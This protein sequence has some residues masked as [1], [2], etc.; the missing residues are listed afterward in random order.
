MLVFPGVSAFSRILGAHLAGFFGVMAIPT[1]SI[2][3]GFEEQFAEDMP[4]LMEES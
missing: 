2:P 3:A 4:D 1:L